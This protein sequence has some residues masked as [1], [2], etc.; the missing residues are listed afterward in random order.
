VVALTTAEFVAALEGVKRTETGW[1]AKCPAHDDRHASLSVGEGDMGHVLV[2]CHAGCTV[3]AI[4]AALRMDVRDLYPEQRE[5]GRHPSKQPATVQRPK[6][7]RGCTL[8]DYATAKGLPVEFLDALGIG[9]IRY[10]SAPAVRFTY[11]DADGEAACTRYR[12][13]LDGEIKVRTKAG[14]KHC[15]YGLNRLALSN[16]FLYAGSLKLPGLDSNQQPSG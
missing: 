11:L 7:R 9:E 3:D 12:V 10:M 13:S 15:L 8:A 2:K 5:G 6:E 1:T 4:V 14:D 16:F